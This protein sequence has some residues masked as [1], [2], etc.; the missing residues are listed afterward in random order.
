MQTGAVGATRTTLSTLLHRP[1]YGP[2][3]IAAEHARTSRLRRVSGLNSNNRIFTQS[4]TAPQHATL[5]DLRTAYGADLQTLDFAGRPEASTDTINHLVAGDTHG[6]IPR[7]FDSPLDSS[8]VSVL[9]NAIFLKA[10]WQSPFQAPVP[11]PF[12]TAGGGHVSVATLEGTDAVPSATADGWRSVQLTYVGGQLT[13]YAILPPEG[14]KTCAVPET[15]T[16]TTLLRADAPDAATVT[17]PRFHLTQ[18]NELLPVLTREGLRPSGDYTGLSP[19]AR[20]SKIVQKV[21][22]SVDENGTTAAAAT[23]A[24][25]VASARVG[26]THVDLNRPFLFLVT[27]TA[28]RTPLFLTRVADP[29]G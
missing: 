19:G 18:T 9:T 17:M 24:A 10:R 15:A 4:G 8:T 12:I 22:I 5:D 3:V 25:F 7:L 6:L 13:A 28:T 21:D 1:A 27:D 20:V 2:A 23:G 16:L 26:A 14:A 11:G 29:R